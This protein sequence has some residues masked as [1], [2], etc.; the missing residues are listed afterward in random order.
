[1]NLKSILGASAAVIGLFGAMQV[2]QAAIIVTESGGGT[3]DN[4]VFNS[5]AS[6]VTGPAL[7][8]TGCLNGA[9]NTVISLTSDENIQVAGGGQARV[10]ASD[11]VGYSFLSINSIIPATF[12]SIVL[13]INATQDG[14]V[15]F[16]GSPGGMSMSFALSG[17]GENFFT[18][19]GENFDFVSFITTG[20]LIAD[21]VLDTRQI[22]LDTAPTAVPEPMS[23]A[24]FGAGLLGLG[25]VRRQ[26][27]RTAL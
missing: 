18:I 16:T 25:M 7:T 10:V 9:P 14:S 11:G 15:T 12:S 4:L 1:M 24:L 26:R 2:S 13:N 5:C 27:N 23:L 8:L 20:T 22:R 17:N 3:G 19:T 21:I 6:A